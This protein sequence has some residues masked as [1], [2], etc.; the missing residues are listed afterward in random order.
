MNNIE[1]TFTFLLFFTKLINR[2]INCLLNDFSLFSMKDQI[3]QGTGECVKETQSD[4]K[5]KKQTR[6]TNGSSTQQKHSTSNGG[7]Q[8]APLQ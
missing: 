8:Q 1:T 3:K 7:F 2:R 4:P 5:L 6:A